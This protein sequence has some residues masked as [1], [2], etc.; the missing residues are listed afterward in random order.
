MSETNGVA[1]LAEGFREVIAGT[2]EPLQDTMV[3]LLGEMEEK[4]D[5]RFEEMDLVQHRKDVR[6]IAKER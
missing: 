1:K 2:L 5:R 6:E 4:M 3:R